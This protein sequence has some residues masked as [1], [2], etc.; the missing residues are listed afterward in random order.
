MEERGLQN[1]ILLYIQPA[2]SPDLN[3]NDLGF[4]RA[5]QSAYLEFSPTMAEEI[6]QYVETAYVEFK[7]QKINNIWITLL[8]VM[9]EIIDN[10]GDNDYKIP[11]I[12]KEKLARRGALPES[13]TVTEAAHPSLEPVVPL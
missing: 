1:K 11:H 4:F 13:I 9:N 2:N 8:N 7:A 10:R 5:L 3:I 6:I 12:G